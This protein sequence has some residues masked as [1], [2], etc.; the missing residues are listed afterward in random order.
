MTV[1]LALT[2]AGASEASPDNS[3]S[4]LSQALT[5]RK[6]AS[7][8]FLVAAVAISG[9]M[10][11]CAGQMR[12]IHPGD[13]IIVI[14]ALVAAPFLIVRIIYSILNGFINNA[15]FNYNA[16]SI[17]VEAFMQALMEF[18]VFALFAASGLIAPKIKSDEYIGGGLQLSLAKRN[19]FGDGAEYGAAPPIQRNHHDQPAAAGYR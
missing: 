17:Y 3:A 16:P 1:A 11:L 4:T 13:K 5:L 7:I 15:T 6:V 10:L 19:T 8:L 18:I 14:C 9:L 2:I 12:L